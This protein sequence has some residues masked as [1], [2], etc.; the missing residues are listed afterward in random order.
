LR[1]AFLTSTPANVAE[2]SGTWVGIDT[3][4]HALREMEH[5]VDIVRPARRWPIHTLERILFNQS[6]RLRD[7]RSYQ[8]VVG[9]DMDGYA[10]RVPHVV[11]I[12]G[13]LAD[14]AGFERGLTRRLMQLQARFER[15]NLHRARRIIATSAYSA[16]RIVELYA[17]PSLPEVVPELIDLRRWHELFA[18][19]ETRPSGRFVVLTVARFYR[20]KRVDVLLDAAARLSRELP[21]FE[22]RIVG[23]GPEEARLR[24]LAPPCAR[25]L[26]TLSAEDLAAE[27]RN[28]DVFC[29]PSVQEGF[30][31]VLL[32]A[33][34]AGKP[35]V[36]V[37]AGAAP[38]VAAHGLL[39][40]PDNAE[41][42]ARAIYRLWNDRVLAA[43]IAQQ[44]RRIVM[45][46]DAPL[47][48]RRFLE[49][50]AGNTLNASAAS[51]QP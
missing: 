1:I 36:A 43:E 3:L 4:A 35:I 48:A 45:Q 39:A 46:Y 22:L 6:L 12:K 47:V 24:A 13:V 5:E 25:F 9:F 28:C 14:E 38:E 49:A 10:I 27:Y 11:A 21:D 18:S 40:A 51:R 17:P 41:S 7:L 32:E 30:G 26:R 15:R 44:G 2:G 34:A 37:R 19:V 50:A 8:L 31:I 29:L 42:L 33:M 23:E 16:R 20:R